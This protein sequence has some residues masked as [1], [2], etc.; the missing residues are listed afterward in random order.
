MGPGLY[1]PPGASEREY[2][3]CNSCNA[4]MAVEPSEMDDRSGTLIHDRF[5][6]EARFSHFPILGLCADCAREET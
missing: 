6:Y 5:G 1:M 3:V 4:V 2:L